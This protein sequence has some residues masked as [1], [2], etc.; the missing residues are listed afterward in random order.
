MCHPQHL[1]E[2][3]MGPAS[4]WL[5]VSGHFRLVAVGE[6]D[7]HSGDVVDNPL[8]LHQPAVV[9]LIHQLHSQPHAPP[10]FPRARLS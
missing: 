10:Q 5:K 6:M 9:R 4:N 3:S 1:S 2:A 8:L 7:A